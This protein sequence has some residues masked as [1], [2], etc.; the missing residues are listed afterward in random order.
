MTDT[1]QQF[2]DDLADQYHRV[3]ECWEASVERQADSLDG[4]IKSNCRVSS[5]ETLDC[6]CGIG[7]QVL[8]LANLGYRIQG[9]DVSPNAIRRAKVE[10]ADLSCDNSLHIFSQSPILS[11]HCP[12]SEQFWSRMDCSSPV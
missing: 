6:S 8:G 12:P 1:V 3:Y 11:K 10:S 5:P 4:L 2:Y 9:S 7:T